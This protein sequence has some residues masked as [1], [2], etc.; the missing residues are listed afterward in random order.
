[1][2]WSAAPSLPWRGRYLAP[3]M[4]DSTACHPSLSPSACT[5]A[6]AVIPPTMMQHMQ[7]SRPL[8][9]GRLVAD[10]SSM[11]A[12][13][14][15]AILGSP[16]I[17]ASDAALR[18]P[19]WSDTPHRRPHHDIHTSARTCCPHHAVHTTMSTPCCPHRRSDTKHDGELAD[20]PGRP[21]TRPTMTR[22]GC[23]LLLLEP[24]MQAL[25][26]RES[27][28]PRLCS[29]RLCPHHVLAPFARAVCSQLL[30]EFEE[31]ALGKDT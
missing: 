23:M 3:A 5:G 29:H 1:M 4:Q 2:S 7:E 9:N 20:R 21:S 14:A 12:L 25:P 26:P 13:G 22:A 19:T 17:E 15:A 6:A 27:K 24:A 10:I 8:G 11:I 30:D 18:P 31:A 28:G 16:T